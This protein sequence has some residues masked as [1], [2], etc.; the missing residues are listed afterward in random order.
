MSIV[1]WLLLILVVLV[2]VSVYVYMRRQAA[3]DPW[4]D[5]DEPEE[6]LD[7]R[8]DGPGDSY[9]VGV[10]TINRETP[11]DRKAAASARADQ[12]AEP[13][14][15][16]GADRTRA[17]RPQPTAVRRRPAPPEPEPEPL[18]RRSAKVRS[19]EIE[20]PRGLFDD[21]PDTAEEHG[22]STRGLE[23]P[24]AADDGV[25]RTEMVA[26]QPAA[27]SE[28]F[29]L[30]VAAGA[31]QRYTGPAIHEALT[32]LGLKFGLNDMYHRTTETRGMT[33]S[34]FAVSNMVQPGTLHPAEAEALET[35]GL[36]MFLL[37]PG[38]LEGRAAMHDM[39]ETAHGI[40]TQL[41][42]TV[43][44]DKRAQLKAQT[45]QFMLDQISEIDRR[46]RLV[47]RR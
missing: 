15:D 6:A 18:P 5:M 33:E 13:V 41:G 23:T 37:V 40:T 3:S 20:A 4:R 34:V 24:G 1:Q 8:A 47:S 12:H 38:P 17:L 11:A 46:A 32:A 22:A 30:Y 44:D 29:I 16:D 19:S 27:G 28:V 9:V 45:A 10:R 7:E 42:G 26:P 31:E 39:M 35:P 36:A 43:L 2:V 21:E 14:E 25:A